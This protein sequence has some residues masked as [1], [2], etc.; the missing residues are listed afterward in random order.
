MSENPYKTPEFISPES[1]ESEGSLSNSNPV[2]YAG[3]W[4]FIATT[5]QP[6]LFWSFRELSLPEYSAGFLILQY[7]IM[8]ATGM[9][10]GFNSSVRTLGG[11]RYTCYPLGVIGF[12][13]SFLCIIG[14][15][16]FF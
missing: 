15:P 3:I 2:D 4:S 13:M 10:L 1:T 6:V 14:I 7:I 16:Q 9:V 5:S 8:V 12:G 11:A